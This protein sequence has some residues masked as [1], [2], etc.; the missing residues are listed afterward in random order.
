MFFYQLIR[1]LIP[2]DNQ[3]AYDFKRIS[4][5]AS[6]FVNGFPSGVY[7]SHSI[8]DSVFLFLFLLYP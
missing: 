3:I 6:V 8:V 5:G 2:F 4:V 1:Q 7:P